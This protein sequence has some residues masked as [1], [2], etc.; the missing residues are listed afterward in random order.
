[1]KIGLMAL[2]FLFSTHGY[3]D[4][5]HPKEAP[6]SFTE[7]VDHL[8]FSLNYD[9]HHKNPRWVA[10]ELSPKRLVD[11]ADRDNQKFVVDIKLSQ[12]SADPQD[13]RNSGY[14]RGHL[15]AAGDMKW[16]KEVMRQSF[17]TSNISPQ[18]PSMNRGK[19]ASLENLVRAWSKNSERTYIVT[20]PVL[21]DQLDKLNQTEISI[22]EYHYKVVLRLKNNRWSGI[23][24]LMDQMPQGRSLVAFVFTI[25]EIEEITGI[26]FYPHLK[27]QE[28]RVIE[29]NVDLALWDFKEKFE[30][31]SCPKLYSSITN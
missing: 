10:Y 13:Y 17:I 5:W 9:H 27:I 24:F 25:R 7:E 6:T 14:D 20:G 30:Y 21:H 4:F 23:A 3:C 26:N 28:S 8:G 31:G 15:A 19:W 11:C 18:S 29:E 16:S 22:P 12:R 1:M 2:V